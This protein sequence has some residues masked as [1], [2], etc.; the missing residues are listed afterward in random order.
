MKRENAVGLVRVVGT[1]SEERERI[2][3]DLTQRPT[4]HDFIIYVPAGY[5]STLTLIRLQAKARMQAVVSL[6][7]V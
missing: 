3:Y 4:Q 5:N 2:R 7:A 1:K 6:V